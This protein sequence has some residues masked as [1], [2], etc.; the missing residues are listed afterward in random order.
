MHTH[1]DPKESPVECGSLTTSEVA[2]SERE[3]VP[4]IPLE[5]RSAG[6]PRSQGSNP[7]L[8]ARKNMKKA[9]FPVKE[10]GLRVP[11]ASPGWNLLPS[12]L[13]CQVRRESAGCI[14]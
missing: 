7:C 11:P 14:G 13:C 5:N 4:I 10:A 6:I 12:S 2:I 1:S 9:R 8:S 3:S